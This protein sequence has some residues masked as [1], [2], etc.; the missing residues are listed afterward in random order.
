M[1]NNLVPQVNIVEQAS[2]LASPDSNQTIIGMIGVSEL[3][4]ANTAFLIGSVAEA[5]DLFG[6][7][8][9]HGAKLLDMISR[10][11]DEGASQIVAVSIGS[12]TKS[13][14]ANEA[15]TADIIAGSSTDNTI[16]VADSSVYS[17]GDVVYLGTGQAYD[18]EERL[19]VASTPSA[20]EVEFTTS[21]QFD[22]YIG[23]TAQVVT[24]KV[25]TD[26]TAGVVALE[27]NEEKSIVV[28]QLNDDATSVLM[29]QT[30]YNSTNNFNTPTVYIRGAEHDETETTVATKAAAIND[31]RMI[32]V[33][34]TLL[35]FNGKRVSSGETAAAVA[36]KLA[37]NGIPKLN[38]NFSAFSGF[39]GVS[40][41]ITNMDSLLSVGVTPLEVKYGVIRIV[42]LLTT[43]TQNNGVPNRQWIEGAVRLNVD[44][45]ERTLVRRLQEKFM[46]SGNTAETRL[47]IATEVNALLDVFA[48]TQIL[49]PNVNLNVPAYKP[50]VVSVDPADDTRV[51]VEVEI[52]PGKPLN[53]ITLSFKVFL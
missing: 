16:T 33:F 14:T 52:A 40:T 43:E 22:H 49:V 29:L 41:K 45:I 20:T 46:Q 48:T 34:P 32:F 50:A 30:A 9:A 39:G 42:R 15:L 13:A 8:T 53:F 21:V 10:G 27:E 5:V 25:S 35:D 2:I 1:S 11:F 47:A 3:G 24:P 23:E 7:N 4:T 19:V 51:I 37:G 18:K 17:A 31:R 28:S 44:F 36:G 12:P 26:Y 38:H 6:A